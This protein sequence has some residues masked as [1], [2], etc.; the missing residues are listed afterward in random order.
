MPIYRRLPKRGF[1][2]IFK[3][4]YAT[5]NVGDLNIFEENTKITPELLVEHKIIKK[6]GDG[7][8]IL[9]LGEI[10]V[11][12][13]VVANAFSKAAKEKIESAGGKAEVI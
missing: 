5:V 13:D 1:T 12:V 9:G 4:E 6:V 3:K 11:K 7:V 2:N 10:N 8:K